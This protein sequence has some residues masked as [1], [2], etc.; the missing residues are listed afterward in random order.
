MGL[1]HKLI[2][3]FKSVNEKTILARNFQT[4]SFRVLKPFY[5]N[6]IL[7]L[8]IISVGAGIHSGDEVEIEVYV[9]KNCHVVLLNQSATKI[10]KTHNDGGSI[11]LCKIFIDDGAILEYYPG[12]N[13]PFSGSRYNQTYDVHI[14][15]YADFAFFEIWSVGRVESGENFS[16]EKLSS[17]LKIFRQLDPIYF[18]NFCINGKSS[19]NLGILSNFRYM[20]SGIFTLPLYM[21][22]NLEESEIMIIAYGMNHA[23]LTFLRGLSTEGFPLIKRACDLVNSWREEKG[24]GK[25]PW[26]SISSALL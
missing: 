25:I 24:F 21:Q 26:Y 9:G 23:G 11:Q 4:G 3:E 10:L 16:F 13:I 18:E 6:N 8:Q 20:L 19:K 22:N 17:N 1:K 12:L 14:S 5:I 7:F 2:M 15:S